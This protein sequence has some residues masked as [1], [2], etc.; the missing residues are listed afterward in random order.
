MRRGIHRRRSWD[1]NR[2]LTKRGFRLRSRRV[3]EQSSGLGARLRAAA[4]TLESIA[5]DRTLLSGLGDEER[6]R[7]IQAAGQVFCPDV[8]ERRRLT[9]A[10]IRRRKADQRQKD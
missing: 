2:V 7:L 9:K 8:A 10:M 3:K 1:G 4:E 6:Q 5:R